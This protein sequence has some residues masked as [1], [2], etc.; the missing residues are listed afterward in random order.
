[1]EFHSPRADSKG[2]RD[3]VNQMTL[4]ELAKH[5][6]LS[7][8]ETSPGR[9]VID[10][11]VDHGG[12]GRVGDTAGPDARTVSA[13]AVRRE[14]EVAV[15]AIGSALNSALTGFWSQGAPVARSLSPVQDRS[16]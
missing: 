4:H 8:R 10:S 15:R 12:H 5:R 14:Q 1:M 9:K 7:L 3:I 6:V 11:R 13:E 2:A 16:R